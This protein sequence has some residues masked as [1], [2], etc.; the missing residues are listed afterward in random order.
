[1]CDDI[2]PGLGPVEL[3]AGYRELPAPCGAGQDPGAHRGAAPPGHQRDG[4]RAHSAG[5]LCPQQRA[6]AGAGLH[7]ESE[8]S[9]LASIY[10]L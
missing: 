7:G 2:I 5:K 10:I 9:L 3:G 1:M 4:D 8:P 6:Q